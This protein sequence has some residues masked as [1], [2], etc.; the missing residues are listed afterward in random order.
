MAAHQAPPSL[1]FF[2]QEHWSGLPFPSPMHES[3]KWKWSRSVVSDPQGSHGVQ[4]S[5][6]L[7][8]WDFLGKSTGVPL[9]INTKNKDPYTKCQV[10]TSDWSNKIHWKGNILKSHNKGLILKRWLHPYSDLV[11]V[12][13]ALFLHEAS[14]R[15]NDL[16][17]FSEFMQGPAVF[18]PEARREL[19]ERRQTCFWA[20]RTNVQQEMGS[21]SS[22]LQSSGPP[23]GSK[24]SPP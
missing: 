17:Y 23:W 19:Q 16:F 7:R 8:P 4:S 24:P 14:N 3:E 20:Q 21:S 12:D 10:L 13:Q 9:L 6:L 2:R 18:M 1:G 22:E 15:V 5:R 11:Y